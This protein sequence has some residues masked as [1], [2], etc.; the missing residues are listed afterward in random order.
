MKTRFFP[1]FSA[2][3]LGWL[4]VLGVEAAEPAVPQYG[5]K[6]GES[7]VYQIRI[8]SQEDKHTGLL[9]G[10]VTYTA[11]T[12]N[13][14]G[15]TLRSSGS[16][17]PS[18]KMK[19]GRGF[20]PFGVYRIGLHYFDNAPAMGSPFRQP[21]DV[22]FDTKGALIQQSD[23]EPGRFDVSRFIIEPLSP[24]GQAPWESGGATLLVQEELEP[25]GPGGISRLVRIKKNN[26]AA[27]E[28]ISYSLAPGTNNTVLIKK[29]M[30]VKTQQM[31]GDSPRL[32]MTGEGTIVFDTKLGVPRAMEFRQTLTEVEE[33]LTRKTPM[34]LTYKLL[35]G[36]EREAALAPPASTNQLATGTNRP[37]TISNP[38][39]A[40]PKPLTDA[41]RTQALADLKS[42]RASTK[43]QAAERL[44][45][46]PATA[47]HRD[48]VL[49]A[50][51]PLLTDTDLFTRSSGAKAL[52]TWGNNDSVTTLLKMLDDRDFSVRWAVFDALATLQ[53]KRAIEP[54][55]KALATGKDTFRVALAL[56]AFGAA[57]EEA[58]AGLLADPNAGTQRE[59]AQLL[60]EIGTRKSVRDLEKVAQ[61]GDFSVKVAAERSIRAIQQREDAATKSKK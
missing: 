61:G 9:Q 25:V 11:R 49:K 33:N 4:L 42:A 37:P 47:K 5:F 12:V 53:N 59:A 16:L 46:A 35:E 48:E 45:A 8:E 24:K 41:E 29:Q 23:A 19:D 21:R 2:F 14:H 51:A 57:A 55:A 26:L 22:V 50:L 13:P 43:R 30:E 60:Q 54:L 34:T 6:Q 15:F 1:A 58:V 20:P 39:K 28:K 38:P 3:Y 17:Q 56:R 27:T 7:Y 18:R 36:K 10:V 52:G 40:E 31:V 32:Q 44:A